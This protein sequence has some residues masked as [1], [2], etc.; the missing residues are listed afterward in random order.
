[1]VRADREIRSAENGVAFQIETYL[2]PHIILWPEAVRGHEPATAQK[3]AACRGRR[4]G[5]ALA[6]VAIG[7]TTSTP[8][9]PQQRAALTVSTRRGR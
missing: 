7:S 6:P 1:V 2:K 3:S 5:L 9:T 4:C 8:F